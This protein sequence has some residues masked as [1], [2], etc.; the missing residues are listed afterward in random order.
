MSTP[1]AD[2]LDAVNRARAEHPEWRYGQTAFNVLY[3]INPELADSVRGTHC[4]PFHRA[5]SDICPAFWGRVSEG[6]ST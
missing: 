1:F 3:Q 6:L 5:E 2:Y 4:D